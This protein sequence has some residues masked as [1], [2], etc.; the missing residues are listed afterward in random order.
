[1][2]ADDIEMDLAF[3]GKDNT[4]KSILSLVPGIYTESFEDLKTSGSMDFQGICPW[5]L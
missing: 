4:F 5:D 2:P 3:A 1:M